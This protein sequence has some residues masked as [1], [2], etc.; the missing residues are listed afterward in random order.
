[1]AATS[2]PTDYTHSDSAEMHQGVR[3]R[4]D[5][6]L[7]GPVV[8]SLLCC[9]GALWLVFVI[10]RLCNHFVSQTAGKHAAD[11]LMITGA[12]ML[13]ETHFGVTYLRAWSEKKSHSSWLFWET[14]PWLMVLILVAI[15][16]PT[17]TTFLCKIYLLVVVAHY[18]MQT[19]TLTRIYLSR[20]NYP[21][22]RFGTLCLFTLINGLGVYAIVA[23]LID[24]SLNLKEFLGLAMPFWG[25]I[26]L[27]IF[28]SCL[29]LLMLAASGF[30]FAIARNL[31]THK[32]FLPYPVVFLLA[33]FAGLFAVSGSQ[34]QMLWLY[35]P[36]FLHGGQSLVAAVAWMRE[37]HVRT[38]SRLLAAWVVGVLIVYAVPLLLV[39]CGFDRLLSYAAVITIFSFHHF[40]GDALF[41]R[42]STGDLT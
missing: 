27:W 7:L 18:A 4:T 39:A 5:V 22:D 16:F 19:Y 11:I 15:A 29:I 6:W 3:R 32:K 26:P 35:V 28:Q 12:L 23:Q 20:A 31:V 30:C 13:V 33:S 40:L 21:L 24:P 36:A 34:S 9:G 38:V 8:D 17:I 14:L 1:M 2:T 41:F 25:P 10:D 37:Q 42:V